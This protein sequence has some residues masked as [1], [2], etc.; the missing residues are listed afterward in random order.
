M[1][2]LLS[3]ETFLSIV[4]GFAIGVLYGFL[5][6]WY[7]KKFFSYFSTVKTDSPL[8]LSS[9]LIFFSLITFIRIS[10]LA[11]IWYYVLRAKNAHAILSLIFFIIGFLLPI[12]QK[13]VCN[14][15]WRSW[16]SK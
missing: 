4:V 13:K 12:V 8:T 3:F 16:F 10:L 2:M 11:L 5:F 9:K 15:A 7:Q 1:M 14:N 6:L